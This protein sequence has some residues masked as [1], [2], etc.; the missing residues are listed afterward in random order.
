MKK[1]STEKRGL[2][3]GGKE[4]WSTDNSGFEGKGKK[5]IWQRRRGEEERVSKLSG[6]ILRERS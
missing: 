3:G 6:L 1:I 4:G 5:S 2:S